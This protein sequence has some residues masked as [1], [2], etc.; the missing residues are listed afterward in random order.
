MNVR[1]VAVAL[2]GLVLASV[3]LAF[4]LTGSENASTSAE[5]PRPIA[6]ITSESVPNVPDRALSEAARFFFTSLLERQYRGQSVPIVNAART[7]AARLEAIPV[8]GTPNTRFDIVAMRY[9]DR[10]DGLRQVTVRVD[11]HLPDNSTQPLAANFRKIAGAW[12]AVSLPTLDGDTES[13]DATPR[14][15]APRAAFRAVR[16]YALAA[17]SFTADTLRANYAEQLRLS[18]GAL[19]A[20][21]RRSPP[22]AAV[23]DA[24]RSGDQR[25]TADIA[26]VQAVEVTA[27]A[28]TFSVVIVERTTSAGDTQTQRT[29]NTALVE[30]HDGRWLVAN[31]TASP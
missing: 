18:T 13:G 25:M 17:R 5:R 27:G 14:R 31:F 11:Q 8:A 9:A 4:T 26:D 10:P 1:I 23:A 24:Y 2:A 20:G 6:G 28:V 29:V 22:T 21:L 7:L 30:L 12:R 16:A 15:A 3:A 19:R